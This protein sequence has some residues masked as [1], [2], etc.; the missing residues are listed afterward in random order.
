VSYHGGD[1][2]DYHLLSGSPYKN[3]GTDGKDLGAD[4]DA[5]DTEIAGVP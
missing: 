5:I 2:G 3:A 4:I 1:G